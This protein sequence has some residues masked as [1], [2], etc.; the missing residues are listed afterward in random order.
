M[1]LDNKENFKR[2]DQMSYIAPYHSRKMTPEFF[3][4]Q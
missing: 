1:T 3:K 4:D 2:L